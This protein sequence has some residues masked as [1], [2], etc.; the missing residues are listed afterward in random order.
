[1]G[2]GEH[3]SPPEK[4]TTGPA[5]RILRCQAPLPPCPAS[6]PLHRLCHP[7]ARRRSRT[8]P[9]SGATRL[10]LSA[11]PAARPSIVGPPRHPCRQV[12]HD[13]FFKYQ[14]R[15]KLSGVGEVYYE[16]KE[17]EASITHARPGKRVVNG[18]SKWDVLASGTWREVGVGVMMR[19]GSLRP[20][21]RTRA[22]A[23]M[24]GRLGALRRSAA[25][26]GKWV[27]V[28][29]RGQGVRGLRHPRPAIRCMG[30]C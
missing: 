7:Y 1:M 9:P 12:L 25:A 6:T 11:S 29:P 13:A 22:Q 26:A 21:S 14:T 28:P 23:R 2:C 8:T 17:F 4:A 20:P 10:R 18:A 15:P 30:A 16:G 24:G 27:W 3:A 5:Q 19:A